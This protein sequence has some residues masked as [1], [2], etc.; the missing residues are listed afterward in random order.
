MNFDFSVDFFL[1]IA[2]F[3]NG[4]PSILSILLLEAST[5]Q[6]DQIYWNN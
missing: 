3:R 5:D 6:I 4:V 1:T 2:S